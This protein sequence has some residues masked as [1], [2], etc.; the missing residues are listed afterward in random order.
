MADAAKNGYGVGA[1]HLSFPGIGHIVKQG[2][3]EGDRWL[4]A[5]CNG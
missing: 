5:N 3:G 2:S 1:A 4:P